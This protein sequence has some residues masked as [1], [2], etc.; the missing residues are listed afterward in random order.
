MTQSYERVSIL[1]QILADIDA[2]PQGDQFWLVER[3][4]QKMR[5]RTIPEFP[6]QD[7]IENL[8]EDPLEYVD[9]ILVV[10][11]Q[12]I[13]LSN[14][15]VTEMREDRMRE[16]GGWGKGTTQISSASLMLSRNHTRR[17]LEDDKNFI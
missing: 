13:K 17:F 9:G 11:S 7:A 14:D 4:M 5:S 3:L 6:V 12:G 15:L 16:I 8:S 2:L 1:E 10:K